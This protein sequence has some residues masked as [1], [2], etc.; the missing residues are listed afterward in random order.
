M[1]DVSEIIHSPEFEAKIQIERTSAGRFEKSEYHADKE[2][3][4]VLGVLVDAGNSMEVNQTEQGDR[5]S[6]HVNLY[7]DKDTPIYI[8]RKTFDKENNISD[9]I[10]AG[11]GERYRITDVFNRAQWGYCMADAQKEGAS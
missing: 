4:T 6:G 2:I 11:N 8:T 7:V 1:I 5:V 3:I 9:V 10:L